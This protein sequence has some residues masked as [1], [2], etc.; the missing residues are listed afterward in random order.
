MKPCHKPCPYFLSHVHST[1]LDVASAR[2]LSRIE[3]NNSEGPRQQSAVDITKNM[4]E[5]KDG[6]PVGWLRCPCNAGEGSPP[7]IR[8]RKT[9]IRMRRTPAS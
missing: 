8:E 9:A 2:C 7:T 4:D 6:E 3:L 5:P 1:Q